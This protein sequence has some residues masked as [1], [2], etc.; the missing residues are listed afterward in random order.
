MYDFPATIAM[1]PGILSGAVGV[2]AAS[3]ISFA[4]ITLVSSYYRFERIIREAEEAPPEEF[5]ADSLDVLRVQFARFLA[6]CARRGTSFSAALIRV[7]DLS[8]P[9]RMDS[10]MVKA[11][12]ESVRPDDVVYL[13]D[14]HT[15]V[16]L[17][18]S[19]PE[20]AERL[21]LRVMVRTSAACPDLEQEAL[22]AGIASYPGHG[23]TGR[24]LLDM[25]V[26]ALEATSAESPIVFPEIEDPDAE[27]QEEARADSGATEDAE[28]S[29][30]D[31]RRLGAGRKA[32]M[33][34][35]L[36]GV[37]KPSAVSRYMQRRMGDLRYKKK[38][39]TLLS[40]GVHKLDYLARVH[41]EDVVDDVLVG[42]SRI[43]Q[44][45]LRMEDLIGRH[46]E[47]A[48]LVLMEATAENAE[49]IGKR[50]AALVQHAVIHSGR[51]KV[52]ASITLGA[53]SY[54]DHGRSL[55]D[56]YQAAQRVLDYHR[57][58]DIRA[59]ATYDP[60]IHAVMP[61]KPMRSIKSAK[62]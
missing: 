54:P 11:L 30:M 50:I 18:E 10:P 62:A 48:F 28:A 27:E 12:K 41:G 4:V 32:S 55:S 9:I 44:D 56:L 52:K 38:P 14:D 35:P 5:D 23:L 51:L 45:H 53:A 7:E 16:L 42:V 47:H 1:A 25:A 46:E 21:A 36:T 20:D 59:Y 19:D 34:D 37:L 3:A 26:G 13:Y 17:A 29:I 31:G 60:A 40:I 39:A 15:V 33:L 43:L 8:V 24:T 22:R 49:I 6:G 61:A 58:N 57:E 2:L